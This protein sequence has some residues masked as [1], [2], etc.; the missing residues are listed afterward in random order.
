LAQAV[1]KQTELVQVHLIF[2]RVRDADWRHAISW[3]ADFTRLPHTRTKLPQ[4]AENTWGP[5]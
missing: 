2:Q 4:P 1:V 5:S 3:F